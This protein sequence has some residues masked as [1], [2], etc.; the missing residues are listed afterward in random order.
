MLR[1]TL[2]NE[3][4][5]RKGEENDDDTF[6][7]EDFDLPSE[8]LHKLLED[9]N[10]KR[11]VLVIIFYYYYCCY[12]YYESNSANRKERSAYERLSVLDTLGSPIKYKN[13]KG[14]NRLSTSGSSILYGPSSSTTTFT[15]PSSLNPYSATGEPTKA[16]QLSRFEKSKIILD[17]NMKNEI[18][19]IKTCLADEDKI[20]TSFEKADLIDVE[21]I[22]ESTLA[23]PKLGSLEEKLEDLRHELIEKWCKK[24]GLVPAVDFSNKDKRLLRNWFRELDYD[25]SGEVNVHELQDPMLSAGILRTKDQ[26]IRVLANIDRNNTMGIDFEEFL[27]ALKGNQL[28]DQSKVRM[29]QDFSQNAHGFEMTTLLN[30]ERRKKLIH[31]V[32]ESLDK[33]EKKVDAVVAKINNPKTTKR[34]KIKCLAEL[35]KVEE[36]CDKSRKL[37]AMYIHSIDGVVQERKEWNAQQR[38]QNSLQNHHHEAFTEWE[39]DNAKH[40]SHLHGHHGMLDRKSSLMELQQHHLLNAAGNSLDVKLSDFDKKNEIDELMGLGPS[41]PTGILNRPQTPNNMQNYRYN[42][43]NRSIVWATMNHK[44]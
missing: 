24:R 2:I 19:L 5:K 25:G 31:S 43:R 15:Y 4:V 18:G 37:H 1:N 33:R 40:G 42:G 32:I 12:N 29:L 34:E 30:E 44:L 23:K 35:A 39:E 8:E 6:R 26:V 22:E 41:L 36:R 3:L 10:K 7:S 13:S 11:L 38:H 16:L 14:N 21:D 20:F 28:A 27:I 9:S 17:N